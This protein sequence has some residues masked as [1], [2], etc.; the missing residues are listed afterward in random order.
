MINEDVRP[1]SPVRVLFVQ[2]NAINESLALTELAGILRE[3]GYPYRVLIEREEGD[4]LKV[5]AAYNPSVVII[6]TSI[7][8]PQWGIAMTRR[9]KSAMPRVLCMLT[10]TYPTFFND[11]IDEEGVDAILRGEADYAVPE[12][13]QRLGSGGDITSVHSIWVKHGG[14]LYKN[15]M[16][17][18]TDLNAMP[19]PD[20]EVYYRYR[21]IR[22]FPLK[23][24][25]SGRGCPNACSYCFNPS[26]KKMTEDRGGPANW[27]NLYSM[28]V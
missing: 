10:G 18:L 4:F 11:A 28:L 15:S 19:L 7:I 12:F 23:R 1:K 5:A 21:F 13:L 8:R 20:R 26:F 27:S 2:D 25:I 24:F 22:D 14:T 3:Q 16:G 9:I 17:P 6:P